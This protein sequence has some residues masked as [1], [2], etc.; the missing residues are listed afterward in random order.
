MRRHLYRP[1][2]VVKCNDDDDDDDDEVLVL[3]LGS[4]TYNIFLIKKECIS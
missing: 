1:A 2:R 3:N 4:F